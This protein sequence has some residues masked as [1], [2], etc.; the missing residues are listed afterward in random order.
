MLADKQ[1]VDTEIGEEEAKARERLVRSD[2]LYA[3]P[4]ERRVGASGAS[5]RSDTSD[6]DI[7]AVRSTDRSTAEE[8]IASSYRRVKFKIATQAGHV[9]TLS[10]AMR[11]AGLDPSAVLQDYASLAPSNEGPAP[12]P[13]ATLAERYKYVKLKKAKQAGQIA[14]MAAEMR[15]AGLNPQQILLDYDAAMDADDE[16]SSSYSDDDAMMEDEV[17]GEGSGRSGPPP[18]SGAGAQGTPVEG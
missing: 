3:D 15:T 5:A 4:G 13:T 9:A 11:A 14:A 8:N 7:S 16:T 1:K 17:A 12:P 6:A 10:I 18:P 2:R